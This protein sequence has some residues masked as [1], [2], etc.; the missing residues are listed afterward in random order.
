MII[1]NSLV[2]PLS[3]SEQRLSDCLSLW[4]ETENNYF[5][6]NYFRLSLNNCIQTIRSVTWV[7]QRTKSQFNNFDGWYESWQN[8]MRKDP[9][10]TWL[11]QARNIIV[12]E[13]DLSTFSKLRIS[14][15]ET[16]FASP[17]M[18]ID[19]SPFVDT[20][21]F[22]KFLAK[23][24][25]NNIDLKVGL[26]CAE[27]R[28]IDEQLKECELLEALSHVYVVL[29]GLLIDAHKNLRYQEGLLKC[30][31]YVQEDPTKGQHPDCMK[32]QE[33][34][35]TI[36]LDLNTGQTLRPVDFPVQKIDD[37]EV[38]KHYP[39]LQQEINQL[40]KSKS[41][42]QSDLKGTADFF[43]ETAKDILK[44]DGFHVPMAILGYPDGHRDLRALLMQNR[45][46][47][48][49]MIRKLAADIEKTG[50]TSVVLINEA[51]VSNT[52]DYCL[53]QLG[54]ESPTLREVLHLIAANAKGE[55]YAKQ[56]FFTRDKKGEINMGK[57][58]N[59][60]HNIVNILAP[61]KEVW[62]R[63][64]IG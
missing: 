29:S 9:V 13:G 44:T 19:V 49:L 62:N 46:E 50:A 7:L 30:P 58:F 36:W 14:I 23:N 38:K 55:I 33:W 1:H 21:D 61:I 51:W 59:I 56:V 2:C 12:K 41:R 42:K 48:H 3:A 24:N 53:T 25:P 5:S 40:K 57:E 54:V 45:T 31:W 17:Y 47:K 20:K 28:W 27:R 34:D 43:F 60:S 26:L 11:V 52:K 6:P 15:I 32:A 18:E 64:P 10:M 37:G 16:W 63:N 39:S 22:I 4:L 8:R 35:R